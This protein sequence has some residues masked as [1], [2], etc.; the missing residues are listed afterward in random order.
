MTV[1]NPQK[2]ALHI[3]LQCV[4]QRCETEARMP[5]PNELDRYLKRRGYSW[6]YYRRVPTRLAQLDRR[7]PVI[8]QALGTRDLV[9][10]RKARDL[11]ASADDDLWASMTLGENVE[12]SRSRYAAALKRVRAMGFG[13]VPA[14]ELSR[15][16]SWDDISSRFEAIL[17]VSTPRE[18]EQAVLGT[19][20]KPMHRFDD[21]LRIFMEGPGKIS[22][23][24]KSPNQLRRS[25]PSA[26]CN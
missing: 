21:A 24:N 7:F 23:A 9:V 20:P 12:R 16:A 22:L 17:P 5:K 19:V 3:A 4:L 10:A 2:S 13:Y 1:R 6:L 15:T 25:C 18:I 11:L 8:E 14:E 26:W